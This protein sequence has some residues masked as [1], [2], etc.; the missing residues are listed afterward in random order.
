MSPRDYRVVPRGHP[1]VRTGEHCSL[2]LKLQTVEPE[3][4]NSAC[5]T[6]LHR[7]PG[8]GPMEA[9]RT[10]AQTSGKVGV[11]GGGELFP[12]CVWQHP[13]Q[14]A[15]AGLSG[16]GPRAPYN[17]QG[18]PCTCTTKHGPVQMSAVPKPRSPVNT[19]RA[20]GA[21]V[22]LGAPGSGQQ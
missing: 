3:L 20:L 19:L 4:R 1:E 16:R 15:A 18:R 21:W 7:C 2:T 12:R 11:G 14:L 5:D 13:R 10:W 17:A 9:S 6:C 22:C 8:L